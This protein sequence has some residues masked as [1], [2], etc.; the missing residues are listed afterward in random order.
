MYIWRLF[1]SLLSAYSPAGH[2]HLEYSIYIAILYTLDVHGPAGARRLPAV[3][4]GAQRQYAQPSRGS[5][6]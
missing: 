1:S 2:G 6:R 4:V 3:S 5:W